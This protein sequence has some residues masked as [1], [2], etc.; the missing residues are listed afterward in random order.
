VLALSHG[1]LSSQSLSIHDTF[2]S[3][4]VFYFV[5]LFLRSLDETSW[6]RN[7]DEIGVG[8]IGGFVQAHLCKLFG[9]YRVAQMV[10]D[11]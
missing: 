7:C 1:A 10:C 3:L 8:E 9:A 5:I 11:M 2:G 4:N 6:W